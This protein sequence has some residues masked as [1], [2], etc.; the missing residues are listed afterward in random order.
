MIGYIRI[1]AIPCFL[2]CPCKKI[3][4]QSNKLFSRAA[5]S[6]RAPLSAQVI[7]EICN[8]HRH[9]DKAVSAAIGAGGKGQHLAAGSD[10]NARFDHRTLLHR[11]KPGIGIG[12]F[13]VLADLPNQHK[14]AAY[15]H[16]NAD[17]KHASATTPTP[18]PGDSL[19]AVL[20]IEISV[21]LG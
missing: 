19:W 6:A 16:G 9:D 18:E 7:H 2:D 1:I 11:R 8:H 10:G 3:F 17:Q 4:I 13:L 14:A 5:K 12:A 20:H 15:C 21:I